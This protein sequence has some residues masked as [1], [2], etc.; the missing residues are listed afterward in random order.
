[1]L[2]PQNNKKSI[3]AYLDDSQ[4]NL[5]KVKKILRDVFNIYCF[6]QSNDL[7]SGLE[8]IYK[9]LLKNA[10]KNNDNSFIEIQRAPFLSL[11][12][13]FVFDLEL[14]SNEPE[15]YRN[16]FPLAFELRYNR[17]LDKPFFLYTNNNEEDTNEIIN[18]QKTFLLNNYHLELK[19]ESKTYR[20]ESI[21]KKILA[22]EKFN[23][24][25][26]IPN[27]DQDIVDRCEILKERISKFYNQRTFSS[28]SE[29]LGKF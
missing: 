13:F 23:F 12:D 20:K 22:L 18:F 11:Y 17:N 16:S 14:S 10:Q 6:D 4:V 19:E 15:I 29:K 24:N 1:M 2:L 26:I 5:I 7:C 9:N 3:V 21:E 25:E 27:K 8:F 28:S